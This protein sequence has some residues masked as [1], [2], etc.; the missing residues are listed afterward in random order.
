MVPAVN[1]IGSVLFWDPFAAFGIHDPVMYAEQK[2]V[3]TPGWQAGIEQ[4]LC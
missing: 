3:G 1:A 4:S 2:N